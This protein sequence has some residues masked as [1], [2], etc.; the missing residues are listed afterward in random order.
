MRTLILWAVTAVCLF[1]PVETI[2]IAAAF[3]LMTFFP[4]FLIW[5]YLDIEE[6]NPLVFLLCGAAFLTVLVY[7]CG[8]FLFYLIPVVISFICVIILEKKKIPF[9]VI[10]KKALL[11][12]GCMV[13]MITY[14]YPWAHFTAFYPPGDEMKLHL[15]YTNSMI[16]E[17]ALPSDYAP[18]Y[19]EITEIS[20]PLGFH[21]IITFVA[22]ASRTSP[23]PAGTVTGILLASLGCV[24]IYFLGK[25]LFDEE[26]GL[27]ASF[28]FVFLSFVSHQLGFSGSYVIL[29][30]ITFYTTAV[31]LLIK[32]SREKTR[33][34]F[35]LAGLFCAACFSTD[36]NTFFPLVF[37]FVFLLLKGLF[38]KDISLKGLSLKDLPLGPLVP[39]FIL[40]SVPQLA[41]LH[42]P[43]PTPL[44]Q[45]FIHEWFR[46]N[47]VTSF[48]DLKIV[49]FSLGPL[50]LLFAL[51]Q[52]FS[53]TKIT[54]PSIKSAVQKE[55][56]IILI[57]M[58]VPFFIPVLFSTYLPFWYVLD[59]VLIFRMLCIPLSFLSGLF[60]V[61]LKSLAQFKWFLTGLILFSTVIHV[62]DPFV[63]LPDLTPTVDPYSLSAYEWISENTHPGS[64][65]CNFVSHGDSST[66]IPAVTTR[67]V[68]LPFHLYYQRDNC[69]SSLDLPE[70]FTDSL[71][72]Q[73]VPG[74]PFAKDMLE[75]YQFSYV[76][77]DGKN[78]V[79][80][81]QFMTSSLYTLEFQQGDIYIFS[82]HDVEPPPC[83][84]VRYL[85][86]DSI[87]Y[88]T[89][90]YFHFSNLDQGTIL[91]IYYADRGSGNVDVE[92]NGEYV[93]TIFR[94]DS[95]DHFLALFVLPLSQ[96][97]S[98]NFLPYEDVFYID[99]LVVYECE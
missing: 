94:F 37:F 36:L 56:H 63:I 87:F 43:S 28:S 49:L 47:A 20:Q 41:R 70:R 45:H 32:A 29:A 4:G 50:L 11:L 57:L 42:L 6:R 48:S 89:K 18:L 52:V 88:R 69:M 24:S 40:F 19:P 91:G 60:L 25:T 46:Q 38:L 5:S 75:K 74:S 15:L 93:G 76:Y 82:L 84:P 44:E 86:G 8:W 26:K 16:Q 55:P 54:V 21:G 71:I 98:V 68:F 62:T 79:D 17:H 65:F 34:T 80:V 77:I 27:A 12:V 90:S 9:P 35:I 1:I 72:L 81:N 97:I 59:S 30:G 61:Q 85:Q 99:Y 51:L 92:I 33:N 73:S 67:R 96:D 13:F 53:F 31:A 39:I 64:S 14:L 2:Q 7:Y 95:G 3:F 23:V 66:W 83:E 22:G 58:T 78:S 10:D